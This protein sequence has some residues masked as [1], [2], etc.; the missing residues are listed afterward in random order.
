MK[1]LKNAEIGDILYENASFGTKIYQLDRITLK[2]LGGEAILDLCIY[3]INLVQMV[4][5]NETPKE[6]EAVGFVNNN[7]KQS[8]FIQPV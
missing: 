5:N 2:D 1:S 8:I 4:Y 7:G 6:I 3:P